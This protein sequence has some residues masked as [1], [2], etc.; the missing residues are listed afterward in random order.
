MSSS[1][2]SDTSQETILQPI[3]QKVKRPIESFMDGIYRF[4]SMY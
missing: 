2:D 3:T 1:S 4:M